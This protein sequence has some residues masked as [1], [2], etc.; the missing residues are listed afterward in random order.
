MR[1][2]EGD[3]SKD[4]PF[5]LAEEES[6]EKFEGIYQSCPELLRGTFWVKLL[7]IDHLMGKDFQMV[8]S[9]MVMN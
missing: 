8:K 3:M 1:E 6:E 4:F 7:I 2:E 9:L 5:P